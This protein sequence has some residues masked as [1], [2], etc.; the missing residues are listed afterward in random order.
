ME[1]VLENLSLQYWEQRGNELWISEVQAIVIP[2]EVEQAFM[3]LLPV[4]GGHWCVSN[5]DHAVI[6]I[7]EQNWTGQGSLAQVCIRVFW[8]LDDK[9]GSLGNHKKQKPCPGL[10]YIQKNTTIRSLTTLPFCINDR[11]LPQNRTEK[12]N[13]CLTVKTWK[14]ASLLAPSFF[15]GIVLDGKSSG[16]VL[17]TAAACSTILKES[18]KQGSMSNH[19]SWDLKI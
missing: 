15:G 13:T 7:D 18:T 17:N 2:Q 3:K 19:S 11:G 8:S 1:G 14:T 6:L 9:S 4:K 12:I 16:R 10:G 5:G